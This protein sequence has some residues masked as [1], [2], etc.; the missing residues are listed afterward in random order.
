LASAQLQITWIGFS[1]VVRFV[2]FQRHVALGASLEEA[3]SAAFSDEEV[4]VDNRYE[5]LR[6]RL[7]VVEEEAVAG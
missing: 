4:V 1:V 3:P 2:R 7:A 6:E 5:D